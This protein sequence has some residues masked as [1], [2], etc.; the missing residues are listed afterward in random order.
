MDRV[1]KA[2]L[3]LSVLT[4][5]LV[6]EYLTK[7]YMFNLSIPHIQYLRKEFHSDQI[8]TFFK[9]YS[10]LADKYAISGAVF[11]AYHLLDLPKA[12]ICCIAISLSHGLANILKSFNHEAR[13]FFVAEIYPNKCR[14]EHGSPSGHAFVSVGLYVTFWNLF[15]RQYRLSKAT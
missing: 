10:E 2:K 11:I 14:F 12:F 7:S 3:M 15:C 9:F 5:F 1:T 8:D 13:P 6:C 4:I